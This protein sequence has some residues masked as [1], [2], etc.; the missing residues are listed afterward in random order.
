MPA[1]INEVAEF[2][3][4]V[5][6]LRFKDKRKLLSFIQSIT[7][8]FGDIPGS[9]IGTL[10]L[11]NLPALVHSD[12][13][14]IFAGSSRS[15]ALSHLEGNWGTLLRRTA[16]F[17]RSH[18]K[19]AA[20]FMAVQ[21]L[22]NQLYGGD[23]HKALRQMRAALGVSAWAAVS[24]DGNNKVGRA[25]LE[26]HNAILS[27]LDDL[28]N[29]ENTRITQ[30]LDD[31]FGGAV[32][33]NQITSKAD[34]APS[35][36]KAVTVT[37]E[38]PINPTAANR[39][40]S[41]SRR[42]ELLTRRVL[43][44]D[45]NPGRSVIHGQ[46][47]DVNEV[48]KSS[49][50]KDLYY[51]D[52]KELV[53]K[54]V[55]QSFYADWNDAQTTGGEPIWGQ[56]FLG[57]YS[58]ESHER[59]VASLANGDGLQR[60]TQVLVLNLTTNGGV[61]STL[62]FFG[63]N[64]A[65]AAAGW[66]GVLQHFEIPMEESWFNELDSLGLRVNWENLKPRMAD[67]EKS[68]MMPI[69]IGPNFSREWM[70]E[71]Q[72][73]R[74]AGISD[75]EILARALGIHKSEIFE[76]DLVST[77]TAEGDDMI[78]KGTT[79]S[80]AR[81]F[82]SQN[83]ANQEFDRTGRILDVND[84][85]GIFRES[86]N[87]QTGFNGTRSLR[88]VLLRP[89]VTEDSHPGIH[90]NEQKR[91]A[92]RAD[93][94][95]SLEDDARIVTQKQDN[96]VGK[97][98]PSGDDAKTVDKHDQG[99]RSTANHREANSSST[100]DDWIRQLKEEVK[101]K[102]AE[103]AGETYVPPADQPPA[104]THGEGGGEPPPPPEKSVE[105]ESDGP[106]QGG[107][108][109]SDKFEGHTRPPNRGL[110][111]TGIINSRD[112]FYAEIRRIIASS[113]NRLYEMAARSNIDIDFYPGFFESFLVGHENSTRRDFF[114]GLVRGNS[115][116]E[117]KEFSPFL[118][119]AASEFDNLVL[120]VGPEL[121]RAGILSAEE[122]SVLRQIKEFAADLPWIP[123]S[124]F[125][126]WGNLFTA[127]GARFG[128]VQAF[129]PDLNLTEDMRPIDVFPN[130]ASWEDVDNIADGK[131]PTSPSINEYKGA[132]YPLR[133]RAKSTRI[134]G[135]T[136]EMMEKMGI[137]LHPAIAEKVDSSIVPDNQVS[138]EERKQQIRSIM[139]DGRHRGAADRAE[140]FVDRTAQK[141]DDG[142]SQFKKA[143]SE[144]EE[145]P[146]RPTDVD[147][148]KKMSFNEKDGQFFLRQDDGRPIV[149]ELDTAKLA[150]H[151]SSMHNFPDDDIAHGMI[152]A[153]K[154]NLSIDAIPFV[155]V[156]N[157]II[158]L[159]S[160]NHRLS[161]SLHINL[162]RVQV[163]VH[164]VDEAKE[165]IKIVYGTE[166]GTGAKIYK[167]LTPL[168]GPP[169]GNPGAGGGKFPKNPNQRGTL[170]LDLFNPFAYAKA[171]RE[172]FNNPKP[173]ATPKVIRVPDGVNNVVPEVLDAKDA[174]I[175]K[176]VRAERIMHKVNALGLGIY[177]VELMLD[178]NVEKYGL[179]TI[180]RQLFEEQYFVT[181]DSY[182][183]FIRTKYKFEE[184]INLTAT[185]LNDDDMAAY[186]FEAFQSDKRAKG[187]ESFLDAIWR[188]DNMWLDEMNKFVKRKSGGDD[189]S[190]SDFHPFNGL[191]RWQVDYEKQRVGWLNDQV[192]K[193]S[194]F[195]KGELHILV[196]YLEIL[197]EEEADE[198]YFLSVRKKYGVA[199]ERDERRMMNSPIESG[200]KKQL[201]DLR[202]NTRIKEQGLP[203]YTRFFGT[204]PDQRFG[205]SKVAA[206]AL[207][208]LLGLSRDKTF[209]ASDIQG[210]YGSTFPLVVNR[211]LAR[212]IEKHREILKT[213]GII[214]GASNALLL[215]EVLLASNPITMLFGLA[216]LGLS[217]PL[218]LAHMND[219]IV[220]STEM[221]QR[222]LNSKAALFIPDP[223]F[224]HTNE[225]FSK[226]VRFFQRKGE[227]S[228]S[229]LKVGDILHMWW[230]SMPENKVRID[231][232]NK[233]RNSNWP[234]TDNF[235]RKWKRE[236]FRDT[237]PRVNIGTPLSMIKI[238]QENI[239][240][241]GP[242][243][244]VKVVP[245]EGVIVRGP[246]WSP[247]GGRFGRSGFERDP[248][249]FRD[250]DYDFALFL[251]QIM[252]GKHQG[253]REFLTNGL[254][255]FAVSDDP[256]IRR[257]ANML[258]NNLNE[259]TNFLLGRMN[260]VLNQMIEKEN[261]IRA[262]FTRR[263]K[264]S[265]F[266]AED[267][268][269][270]AHIKKLAKVAKQEE[271]A[272]FMDFIAKMKASD[273]SGTSRA[274]KHKKSI[275]EAVEQTFEEQAKA[276]GEAFS[277]KKVEF[278]KKADV[279]SKPEDRIRKR[280]LS[281]QELLDRTA[282]QQIRTL[283]NLFFGEDDE[284][285]VPRE[286][287]KAIDQAKATVFDAVREEGFRD[288]ATDFIEDLVDEFKELPKKV[289]DSMGVVV[290]NDTN[291]LI[292]RQNHGFWH[293]SFKLLRTDNKNDRKN[294]TPA[295]KGVTTFGVG[296]EGIPRPVINRDGEHPQTSSPMPSET[297][298]PTIKQDNKRPIILDE[299]QIR[300]IE[301]SKKSLVQFYEERAAKQQL[302][303]DAKKSF[304][305][306]VERAKKRLR[307]HYE[308][309]LEQQQEVVDNKIAQ[310]AHA[311]KVKLLN[312]LH[313]S[314]EIQ[315]EF[316]DGVNGTR[317]YFGFRDPVVGQGAIDEFNTVIGSHGP[318]DNNP[319]AKLGTLINNQV[320]KHAVDNDR[321]DEEKLY[322]QSKVV[323][324][325]LPDLL[326]KLDVLALKMDK[327][328]NEYKMNKDKM[329]DPQAYWEQ[330]IGTDWS[331]IASQ[332]NEVVGAVNVGLGIQGTVNAIRQDSLAELRQTSK[333][334]AEY[335]GARVN[336]FGDP[337]PNLNGAPPRDTFGGA[338][339]E[340]IE[341]GESYMS[342]A[343][344]KRWE[345]A[346][347]KAD[348][349][350]EAYF[351]AKS[352]FNDARKAWT[353]RDW[354]KDEEADAQF[355]SD[356]Q[357]LENDY[358]QKM[359]Q[360]EESNKI[361]GQLYNAYI[362]D[363]GVSLGFGRNSKWTSDKY[364]G[365]Y[366]DAYDYAISKGKSHE[367][368]RQAGREA[369]LEGEASRVFEQT[370]N[371][372]EEENAD[373]IEEAKL[374]AES[375][376]RDMGLSDAEIAKRITAAEDAAKAEVTKEANDAAHKATRGTGGMT[377]RDERTRLRRDGKWSK[378]DEAQFKKEEKESRDAHNAQIRSEYQRFRKSGDMQ[379]QIKFENDRW[380]RERERNRRRWKSGPNQNPPK[381]DKKPNGHS[382]GCQCSR[383]K[384]LEATTPPP[385]P[386]NKPDPNNKPKGGPKKAPPKPP[387][388]NPPPPA[389]GKPSGGRLRN[390][391][392]QPPGPPTLPGTPN[393]PP[394]TPPPTPAEEFEQELGEEPFEIFEDDGR[395]PSNPLRRIVPPGQS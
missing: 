271:A 372:Y 365:K 134:I 273:G 115:Y 327:I 207:K 252:T 37:P 22:A 53:K 81:K 70:P 178:E 350:D 105:G 163:A 307:K 352:R 339:V 32:R 85:E 349:D 96:G 323:D 338:E 332:Y 228:K 309:R 57:Q 3:E 356:Y 222:V 291:N 325:R 106:G 24:V 116:A 312:K 202:R 2:L 108:T 262:Y 131:P 144:V 302:V 179:D 297:D 86:A 141:V 173:K 111:T 156:D 290:P 314:N 196:G 75:N 170:L 269:I 48:I 17:I 59:I 175:A 60:P 27:H 247:T 188:V 279:K 390:P 52:S 341:E 50:G 61:D 197:E 248:F 69:T 151:I 336:G 121:E 320:G 97:E 337:I 283:S 253:G 165:L 285:M 153:L 246:N 378:E 395:G 184:S 358:K 359:Q 93:V 40:A 216:F 11:R 255:K 276:I 394:P 135:L 371:K 240:G 63:W 234:T 298:A 103:A 280:G 5:A 226:M 124:L 230:G 78:P 319:Q 95:G 387:G 33:F 299:K 147:N 80:G 182:K 45:K 74:D 286:N 215:G 375:E 8:V 235:F 155:D 128:V 44:V 277:D 94:Q 26:E 36:I 118:R 137:H 65:L 120:V 355:K 100:E 389:P 289:K 1:S 168:K 217:V 123:W 210:L 99:L 317:K 49:I 370:K 150:E 363:A 315:Q 129:Q 354:G 382:Y 92:M 132:D 242:V 41:A 122:L 194:S 159:Q 10:K 311:L 368:A 101:R 292:E 19:A 174:L 83:L 16:Q 171:V 236:G 12:F 347:S 191:Q 109:S 54:L 14:G 167:A 152:E 20:Q 127:E 29:F 125:H 243:P 241:G 272:I 142:K 278:A 220:A 322:K 64:R 342:K 72:V 77:R 214:H 47:V 233:I 193:L 369:T 110:N 204:T 381:K 305:K 88:Q 23:V 224:T 258:S 30:D 51:I 362:E 237:S 385:P 56:N 43:E 139:E 345:D 104:N 98:L 149:V 169:N 266:D 303:L 268:A 256:D 21:Q 145:L 300:I 200:N 154:S 82:Q 4:R 250:K 117:L 190:V 161:T 46:N 232:Y 198:S 126:D 113:E 351:A 136:K 67:G 340:S 180:R 333:A 133:D 13:P 376:G 189:F 367:E 89:Q 254:S 223:D 208:K 366:D 84:P 185:V 306:A 391:P 326:D 58:A 177:A 227:F 301:Q 187:M 294:I 221:I 388:G 324:E 68:R 261:N 328:V 343:Q 288:G 393:T 386:P 130:A 348:S 201:L 79:R 335:S 18:Q 102:K 206:A 293:E 213:K 172:A 176:R 35:S 181:E 162:P 275:V 379:K 218:S 357:K 373:R 199:R 238:S 282:E 158:T 140:A 203:I 28:F 361:A 107:E 62:G 211:D 380:K 31:L 112:D 66:H 318:L 245:N 7:K 146:T 225:H 330:K 249:F 87:R 295:G 138:I 331:Q 209:T 329:A 166:T 344:L 76:T 55:F 374:R 313:Y 384:D 265:I 353:E 308:Q 6:E 205:E 316:A 192:R 39:P 270:E 15:S 267:K 257:H 304:D 346:N 183:D 334:Y 310:E 42:Q 284:L 114:I 195:T 229:N 73:Y 321:V 164:T 9:I 251:Y 34:I 148:S 281:P 274:A 143:S 160:G 25:L 91:A 296:S 264:Y 212:F 219:Q 119:S 287:K 259:S 392:I 360:A 239:T 71:V 263:G 90:V 364:G 244:V 157:G 231:E 383:C 377:A 38:Q 186:L 260:H